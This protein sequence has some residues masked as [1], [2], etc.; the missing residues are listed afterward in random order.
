MGKAK[1]S[2]KNETENEGKLP[3]GVAKNVGV[4]VLVWVCVWL[5]C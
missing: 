5:G 2:H 4:C 3:R 1:R